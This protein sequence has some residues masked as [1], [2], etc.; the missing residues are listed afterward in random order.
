[1]ARIALDTRTRDDLARSLHA[2]LKD[3]LGVE[4]GTFEILD[5]MDHLADTL[6]PHYYNRGLYDAQA[7][8]KARMDGIVEAIE[9]VEKPIKR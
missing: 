5:L 8:V 3:E 2:Y 6:G 4:V 7:V 9:A 1:V